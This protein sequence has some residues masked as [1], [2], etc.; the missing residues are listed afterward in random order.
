MSSETPTEASQ[1]LDAKEKQTDE[2]SADG[3]HGESKT[4]ARVLEESALVSQASG[5]YETAD[6][7]ATL[8]FSFDNSYSRFYNKDLFY[9]CELNPL[10]MTAKME[11]ESMTGTVTDALAEQMA[12]TEE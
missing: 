8:S 4:E 9:V 6:H 5:H 10:V 3:A 7:A 1:D 2:N 11:A 12:P